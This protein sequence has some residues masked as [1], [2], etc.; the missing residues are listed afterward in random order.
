MR[1]F[2]TKR[3]R[4]IEGQ[5]IPTAQID[6]L[7]CLLHGWSLRSHR[8][9]EGNKRFELRSLSGGTQPV[10]LDTVQ[11][12]RNKRLIETNHKFPSATFLLTGHGEKVAQKLCDGESN[13]PLTAK[14]FTE[15][16]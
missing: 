5:W 4:W 14:K 6:V 8:D 10:A 16:D 11:K 1:Q 3:G 12:M 9:L 15:K 13:R 2:F 7:T